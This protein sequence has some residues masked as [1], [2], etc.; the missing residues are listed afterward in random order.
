MSERLSEDHQWTVEQRLASLTCMDEIGLKLET[1]PTLAD[2]FTWLA[3]RVPLAMP[4]PDCCV[5]AIEFRGETYGSPDAVSLTC[6]LAETIR[7]GGESVGEICVA[8]EEP[9]TLGQEQ[10]YLLGRI[11]Q[12]VSAYVEVRGLIDKAQARA[13]QLEVLYEL[14]RSLSAHLNT[15]QVLEEIYKG[16]SQLVDASNFY[17]GVYNH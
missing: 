14:G 7:R 3:G 10:R 12:R 4:D 1:M 11:A 2:L 6:R 5:A 16:V 9:R 17:I 15:E 13:V 8:Y